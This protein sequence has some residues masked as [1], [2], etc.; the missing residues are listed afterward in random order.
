[1]HHRKFGGSIFRWG[2]TTGYYLLGGGGAK[3]IVQGLLLE[4]IR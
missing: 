2:P 1:M 3:N 4:G